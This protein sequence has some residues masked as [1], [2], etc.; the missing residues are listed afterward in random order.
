[1]S[2]LQ[3]TG[4]LGWF[5]WVHRFSGCGMQAQKLGAQAAE[6]RA[7][8]VASKQNLLGAHLLGVGSP[9]WGHCFVAQTPDS[10]GGYVHLLVTY[11]GLWV[12]TIPHLCPYY[13]CCLFFMS[14]LPRDRRGRLGPRGD[15]A[16]LSLP[17]LGC[18]LTSLPKASLSSG[19]RHEARVAAPTSPAG[20]L[21]GADSQREPVT[22]TNPRTGST[23]MDTQTTCLGTSQG[24]LHGHGRARCVHSGARAGCTPLD[25]HTRSVDMH[26][27]STEE[28]GQAAHPQTS[29]PGPWTCTLC[30]PRSQGRL[31]TPGL[32]EQH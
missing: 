20:Q 14:L 25:K 3:H 32:P 19:G 28:P 21:G 4:S 12:L 23:S 7:L 13:H 27:L 31:H 10:L 11:P 15:G 22:A 2:H 5:H 6:C 30:P 1:M 16:R 9:D 26:A 8:A 18:F 29:T 24:R 17:T